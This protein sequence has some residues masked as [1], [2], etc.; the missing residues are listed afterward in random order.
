[1]IRMMCGA[2]SGRGAR[3]GRRGA[4]G[5]PADRAFRHFRTRWRRPLRRRAGA[6]KVHLQWLAPQRWLAADPLAVEVSAA[7]YAPAPKPSGNGY[8]RNAGQFPSRPRA[9]CYKGNTRDRV[10][11]KQIMQGP[12]LRLQ[13][14]GSAGRGQSPATSALIQMEFMIHENGNAGCGARFRDAAYVADF[15]DVDRRSGGYAG[16]SQTGARTA[17]GAQDGRRPRTPRTARIARHRSRQVQRY[18]RN[19]VLPHPRLP[20]RPRVRVKD[21]RQLAARA[22]ARDRQ[23]IGDNAALAGCHRAP[24]VAGAAGDWPAD[25]GRRACAQHDGRRKRTWAQTW[26]H[27]TNRSPRSARMRMP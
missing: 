20:L 6:Y 24:D 7:G 18:Q 4:I 21:L 26:S 22:K 14:M 1:M 8:S 25:A 16:P 9:R 11:N 13:R 23:A 19:E 2:R 17:S 5:T 10:G 27:R 12:Q 3:I 15:A